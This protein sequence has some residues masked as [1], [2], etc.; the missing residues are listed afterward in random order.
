[1][2][3]KT[4]DKSPIKNDPFASIMG[5]S[6]N[7]AGGAVGGAVGGAAGGMSASGIGAIGGLAGGVIDTINDDPLEKGSVAMSAGSGALKAAGTGAMI[8]SVIPGVGTAIGA[9]VGA[10]IGGVGGLIKGKKAKKEAEAAQKAEAARREKMRIAGLQAEENSQLAQNMAAMGS[11]P[12]GMLEKKLKGIKGLVP[13]NM[14]AAQYKSS[15]QMKEISG[16]N[17]L[18]N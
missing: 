3:T 11:S 4:K 8:G 7:Y 13:A 17:T 15:L 9:G 18:T 12:F 6:Q 16:V 5:P 1:M 10:L 14:S 2:P